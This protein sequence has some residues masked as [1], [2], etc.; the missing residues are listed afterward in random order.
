MIIFWD[1]NLAS[2]RDYALALFRAI[3]PYRK[4]WSSQASIQA[5]RDEAF[6]EAAAAS[7]CKQLFLGLESVFEES[8]RDV[9]KGWSRVSEY[10][11]VVERIHSFGIAVQA[12]IVFGF[13]HDTEAIFE[14]TLDFLEA[15]GVQNA[16][17]NILTP[18]PGTRLYRRL[19]AEGR[20]LTKDWSRY[21]GRADVVFRPRLMSPEA[22]LE[23]YRHA[24]RRFYSWRSL[25][26]RLARSPAGLWWTLPLNV[27]YTWALRR[28]R[29]SGSSS[30]RA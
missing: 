21:N 4:W 24:N 14:E 3:A 22:L 28:R 27:A 16:T 26:T 30:S 17:F 10:A 18:F 9:H 25:A 7:G 1:D 23:G 13:D 6:L 5:G 11:R 12:G 29:A 2:D 19:E 20:I 8:M 15:A